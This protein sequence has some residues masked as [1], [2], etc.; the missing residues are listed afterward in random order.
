[1]PQTK[2]HLIAPLIENIRRFVAREIDTQIAYTQ[3]IADVK[4]SNIYGYRQ[5]LLDL[6]PPGNN[7][8]VYKFGEEG[9][10]KKVSE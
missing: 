5:T 3:S 2:N 6:S 8:E 7:A 9:I 4:R 10:N 1:M